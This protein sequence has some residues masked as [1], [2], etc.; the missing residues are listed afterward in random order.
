[1]RPI[2][3]IENVQRIQGDFV[4][5][6]IIS[7]GLLFKKITVNISRIVLGIVF[8][9]SGFVKSVDPWGSVYKIK[10]Y[11]GVFDLGFFD[12]LALPSAFFLFAVEFGMGICLLLGVYRRM[13]TIFALL[14]M[15]IMTPLTLHS[16]ITDSVTDCG[17]FGD[18][19]TL[20][21][22][23]TFFKNIPLLLMAVCLYPW[24]KW[25]APLFTKKSDPWIT[26]WTYAFILGF[27]LYCFSYLPVLDFRPYK[28]GTHIPASMEIPEDAEHPVF[29]VKLIYSQN[30]VQREF[31]IDDY[32]KED[33]TWTFVTS[34]TV[35]VKKGYEPPIHDFSITA[36]DGS[37][38]TGDVLSDSKY[39]FL[40]I[41]HKLE[42][43]DESNVEQINDIYDYSV[44][45]GYRFYALTSSL[46]AGIS[47]WITNTGAEYPFCTM[48]DVTLKTV[49]RSNPGLLLLKNGTV[50]NKWAH[51]ALPNLS[52]LNMPLE[53]CNV[54]KIPENR[55]I[56]NV[57]IISLIF[58]VP[59][60]ILFLFDFFVFRKQKKRVKRR[61]KRVASPGGNRISLIE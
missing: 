52:E 37:D 50:I 33:S 22:W 56:G 42:E 20:T 58:L 3:Q 29:D 43:A 14:F 44:K 10:E 30:G 7:M 49:I 46:P 23:Q 5:I 35:T 1:M 2:N 19:L 57:I 8:V 18:A 61:N 40:L 13:N 59:L 41:A 15:A 12:F 32:P 34:K 38:I 6:I 9:L 28:I 48:D 53:N 17:C 21:N 31:T 55:S 60:F 26:G 36:E 54:G 11:L 27:G 47:E 24:Y 25:M 45:F 39:T 51:T 16:A 4:C